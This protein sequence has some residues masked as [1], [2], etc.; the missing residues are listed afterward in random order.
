MKDL[1][2]QHIPDFVSMDPFQTVKLCDTWFD[3]DYNLMANTFTKEQKDLAF[4]F[5]NT[6]L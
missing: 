2:Q 4:N 6:V 1:I 3:S 5:L